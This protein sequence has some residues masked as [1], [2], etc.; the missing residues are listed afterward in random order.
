MF[1][2]PRFSLK[3]S[4]VGGNLDVIPMGT[5]GFVGFD[6]RRDRIWLSPEA[7]SFGMTYYILIKQS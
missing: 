2:K 4:G 7:D 6:G 3:D 5:L 1:K